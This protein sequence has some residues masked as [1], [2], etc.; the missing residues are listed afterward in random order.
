MIELEINQAYLSGRE[1]GKNV[2]NLIKDKIDWS[3]QNTIV[4]PDGLSYITDSFFLGF[5]EEVRNRTDSLDK[6]IRFRC[7]NEYIRSLVRIYTEWYR[8][9][10]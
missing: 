1:F 8:K 4:L 9:Q 7:G 5:T 2:W 6:V 3:T 10:N